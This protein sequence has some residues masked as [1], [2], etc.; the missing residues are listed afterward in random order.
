MIRIQL[1]AE[2]EERPTIVTITAGANDFLRNDPDIPS[3]ARRVVE[4][5]DLLLNNDG[6]L[7]L[8]LRSRPCLQFVVVPT[9][10]RVAVIDLYSASLGRQIS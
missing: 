8:A 10:S 1:D 4:A 7:A 3:L 5:I 9:G 2:P 6:N